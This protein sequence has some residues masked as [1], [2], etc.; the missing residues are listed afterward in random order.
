MLAT[1]LQTG[2]EDR[3]AVLCVGD[4][5]QG[6]GHRRGAGVGM[7]TAD[8]VRNARGGGAGE[9]DDHVSAF[10]GRRQAKPSRASISSAPA[11]PQVPGW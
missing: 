10:Q 8:G 11:G 1:G 4:R 3:V 5:D 9:T 6:E 7:G 2:V